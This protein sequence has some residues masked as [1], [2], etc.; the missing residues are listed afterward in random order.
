LKLAL[1]WKWFC[2]LAALI[3]GLL[4][5]AYVW[6]GY[7][8]PPFLEQRIRT[9]FERDAFLAREAFLPILSDPS[10]TSEINPLAHRLS[11]Q[12]GLRVTVIAPNGAVLGESDKPAGQLSTIENHLQR[13]EVQA[14]L[15]GSAGISKGH[16]TSV[17]VD[18]LYVAVPAQ[19]G[20]RLLGFVRVALPL[21]E[22]A[23][24]TSHVRRVVAVA[25]VGVGLVALPVMLVLTRRVT[26]P[27]LQMSAAAGQIARGTFPH[28]LRIETGDELAQ[29]GTALNDM[30][31]Q[32]QARLREL[33]AEKNEL[34]AVLASMTEGVLVVDAAGKVRLMNEAFRQQ[35][36]IGDEAIGRTIIEAV[37]NVH[38]QEMAE[39]AR[40][41]GRTA[42][43]EISFL[44]PVERIFDVDAASLR[45]S[46]GSH[47]GTVVVFHDITRIKQLENLRKEF[48]ANVSHELRTPLSIIKGYVETLLDEQPVEEQDAKQ[49][50]R[51]IEK[52][53]R[54]L[55]SL[56]DD[57]LTIS[58]LESQQTRLDLAAV[59]LRAIAT[60]VIEELAAQAT[61]KSIS[62]SMD[63]G[64]AIPPVRGD[65]QRLH[66]VFFNLLDNA[67][68][69]TAP[70]GRVT[71]TAGVKGNEVEVGV[72]DNGP[73]IA[74]EHL[75]R[76]F[77]RFYRVDKARSREL[78]GTGLGLAIVK[79]IVQ[80]HGG[81]V[82][83][84]SEIAKGSRFFFTL[85][86]AC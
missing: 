69:Y 36:Q 77:E 80:A 53:S 60:S 85:P 21:H 33:A 34:A 1:H 78:G 55:E 43:R 67:V 56:I 6:I 76:V 32:L 52:H 42:G 40:N 16:S 47:A 64:D 38:L 31:A 39:Q 62:V 79:H 9:E 8:L 13:P 68:K 58:A 84:E 70:G 50:L 81:R 14:A 5:V 22:I 66:Q 30:S 17:D 57:L 18:L 37:R 10:R 46:D 61:Q 48:V 27:I 7:A 3:A 23:A 83:A 86:R 44:T 11:E 4:V 41:G 20:Q 63:I 2:G 19:Q 24:T 12:T 25:V 35:F 15:R 71:V 65:P 51:T 72:A 29:L 26:S 49:F 75:P 28:S 45:G 59:S 54:R 82:W 74:A 73:G